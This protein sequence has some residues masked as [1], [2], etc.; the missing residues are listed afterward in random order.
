MM[1][2]IFTFIDFI[3]L[4]VHLSLQHIPLNQALH[5]LLRG[6]ERRRLNREKVTR[7]RD[8]ARCVYPVN[9][10]NSNYIFFKPH[11]YTHTHSCRQRQ[12]QHSRVS[13]TLCEMLSIDLKPTGM[14]CSCFQGWTGVD[15]CHTT[16]TNV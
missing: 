12:K 6:R 7:R 15:I 16:H 2:K 8:N 3:A 13:E 5:D 14:S 4:S 1:K 11:S 10:Q 9:K